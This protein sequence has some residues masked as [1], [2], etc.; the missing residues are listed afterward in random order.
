MSPLL[1]YIL[2]GNW[3][4]YTLLYK[5]NVLSPYEYAFFNHHDWVY[6]EQFKFTC[7]GKNKVFSRDYFL[8]ICPYLLIYYQYPQRTNSLKQFL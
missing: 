1:W 2:G 5:D 6:Y 4:A 8:R 3:V 7:E